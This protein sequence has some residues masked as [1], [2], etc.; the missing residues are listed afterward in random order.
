MILAARGG[1]VLRRECGIWRLVGNLPTSRR[2]IDLVHVR[3][4]DLR[5]EHRR[6]MELI[7]FGEPL[8]VDDFPELDPKLLQDLERRAMIVSE[9]RAG[10]VVVRKA[11]N[12]WPRRPGLQGWLPVGFTFAR[13]APRADTNPTGRPLDARGACTYPEVAINRLHP[14]VLDAQRTIGH[15]V[16]VAARRKS[17][18]LM[19]G[20]LAGLAVIDLRL[21]LAD[22]M[23]DH[24]RPKPPR[25]PTN[26]TVRVPARWT[27]TW[28]SIVLPRLHQCRA[29]GAAGRTGWLRICRTAGMR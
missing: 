6:L 18:V 9:D 20:R 7:A 4:A 1:G 3:M 24:H 2:L 21:G 17:G 11:A 22:P 12:T 27:T 25:R 23:T 5:P 15:A 28:H 10:E 13:C 8:A 19:R 29:A 14:A 26:A 16:P